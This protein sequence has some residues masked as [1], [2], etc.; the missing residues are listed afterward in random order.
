[1]TKPRF[2]PIS[3]EDYL[4]VLFERAQSRLKEIGLLKSIIDSKDEEIGQLKHAIDM[5]R[6][7]RDSG[8]ERL[9]NLTAEIRPLSEI[10][11]LRLW[12]KA[13]NKCPACD[14]AGTVW[15]HPPIICC[16]GDMDEETYLMS[17]R[18]CPACPNFAHLLSEIDCLLA[19]AQRLESQAS[20]HL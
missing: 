3:G 4:E 20:E 2:D 11:K 19:A 7:D 15:E 13:G 12:V 5:E 16:I 14:G 8:I 17:R 9:R 6:I 18:P 1:M 10:D